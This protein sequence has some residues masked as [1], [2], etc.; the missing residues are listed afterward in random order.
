MDYRE[1]AII[2]A[3]ISRRAVSLSELSDS[4]CVGNQYLLQLISR[5]NTGFKVTGLPPA[6]VGKDK[7]LRLPD[8]PGDLPDRLRRYLAGCDYDAYTLTRSERRTILSLIILNATEHVTAEALADH[9][10]VSRNTILGDISSVKSYFA[11]GGIEL[12][13]QSGRGYSVRAPESAIRAKILEILSLNL[14]RQHYISVATEVFQHLLMGELCAD[15]TVLDPIR[16][17]MKEE[18]NR[19]GFKL[20]DYSFRVTEYELVLLAKRLQKG[21]MIEVAHLEGIE[22]SSKYALSRDI[23]MR[24]G[25]LFGIEIPDRE[26]GYFVQFLRRKSYVQ[27][28]TKHVDEMQDLILIEEVI[29]DVMRALGISFYLENDLHNML[30]D[31]MRSVIYRIRA[32]DRPIENPLLKDIKD[33]YETAFAVVR[34][35]V[36]PIEDMLGEEL[37]DDE[38]AFLVMFFE[39][40]IGQAHA[41]RA[42]SHKVR[43]LVVCDMGRTVFKYLRSQ[44]ASLRDLI[45]IVDERT[46]HDDS[47]NDGGIQM[48]ISTLSYEMEGAMTVL[49]SSPML[50]HTDLAAIQ[51]CA[52]RILMDSA[53]EGRDEKSPMQRLL[54]LDKLPTWDHSTSI[55]SRNRMDLRRRA[56]T[57]EEALEAAGSLLNHDGSVAEEAVAFMRDGADNLRD[58]LQRGRAICP[59]CVISYVDEGHGA[60]SDALSVVRLETPLRIVPEQEPVRYVI[61]FSYLESDHL[62]DMLHAIIFLLRDGSLISILDMLDTPFEAYNYIS[63]II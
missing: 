1:N 21:C 63:K 38:V 17:I 12:D 28:S 52:L 49:V 42:I 18:E 20:S 35:C 58:R 56:T 32:D 55:L 5:M 37:S 62:S 7:V 50:T 47:S 39:A 36:R 27:S 13:S 26:V 45:D 53:E 40:A 31:H 34:R 16:T 24:I 59:G 8:T 23:L 4:L 11:D 3:L 60:L 15:Q 44:L 2:N 14:T 10:Q 41:E 22:Q 54:T 9:L 46:G 43:T 29:F 48:V 6:I 57:L 51:A 33:R 19:H 25:G 30:V 61:G